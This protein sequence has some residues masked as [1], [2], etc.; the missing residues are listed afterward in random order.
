MD[1]KQKYIKYKTKYLEQEG[2]RRKSKKK[3]H[4]NISINKNMNSIKSNYT[5]NVSEPWFSLIL[6]FQD[7]L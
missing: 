6:L 1:Y 7:I 4:R 3:L 2:G 5:E